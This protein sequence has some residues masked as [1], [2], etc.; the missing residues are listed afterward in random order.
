MRSKH[1]REIVINLEGSYPALRLRP[2][3]SAV[4]FRFF[5]RAAD[6]DDSVLEV[7]VIPHQGNHLAKPRA[8][9]SRN[10]DDRIE[11][12]SLKARNQ[13]SE[14]RVIEYVMVELASGGDPFGVTDRI[15]RK[16]FLPDRRAQA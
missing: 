15:A 5:H 7:D 9:E 13:P 2:F 8:G 12:R 14:L 6:R 11:R 10:S 1:L 16:E 3:S 4:A